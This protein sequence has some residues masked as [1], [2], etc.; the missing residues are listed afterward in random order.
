MRILQVV[1]GF[2]PREW[3]GTE[4]MTLHLARA[5]QTRGH[6]LTVLTRV[7]EPGAVEFSVRED[8]LDGLEVVQIV[9][10]YTQSVTFRLL[11]DNS[12]FNT[13]FLQ[14]LERLRPTVVHFQHLQHLSVE[15]LLLASALGYPTVLSLHDFFFP[16]HR[17]HLIDAQ[18]L[19]CPGPERGERCVACLHPLAL[20]EEA[21]RR[22]AYM[23]EALQAPDLILTPSRFLAEKIQSYFPSARDKVCAVPLGV[24][25][26]P[27][28]VRER[29]AGAPLRILY[30]GVLLP[31]KGAH[32]LLKALHELPPASFE[33]SLYGAVTF[34]GQ[35]YAEHL[36][37]AAQGLPVRFHDPYPYDQLAAVLERHD[38][39]V[40]PTL[41]EETFSIL[42]RE[43][44]MAGMPVVAARRGALTE[45]VQDGVNGLLFEP[46]NVVDLRRCLARLIS[47]PGLVERLRST[48]PRIK[49]V[50]EYASDI[51]ELYSRITTGPYRVQALEQRLDARY[52]ASTTLQQEFQQETERLRTAIHEL[53]AL[54]DTVQ[55]QRDR[56][57]VEKTL[58]E[59]ERDCAFQGRDRA[60]A[61]ARELEDILDTRE[62]Q[63]LER[64]ARLEA[65]YTSTTWKLY[66]GY[67]ALVYY[68]FHRPLGVLRH[69]LAR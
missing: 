40:M 62:D 28:I 45:A 25:R 21:R 51:E 10:N 37:T 39:L 56:L 61:A 11:Y 49:T 5:L 7:A 6:E 60:L 16:C 67:A 44:F 1:H 24:P 27:P 29:P 65:I 52:R 69:W 50:D 4:L 66:R 41:C 55:A 34:E 68:L 32:V 2:P 64:N 19:L 53:R 42:T 13:P 17:I 33:A 30:V 23:E 31:H 20:P 57:S 8:R 43:A 12:F 22:F 48:D 38:V 14:L 47:E 26:V 18:N 15:L 36:R 46:E 35:A 59:Q 63:L 3:A 54:C 58:A 9:N